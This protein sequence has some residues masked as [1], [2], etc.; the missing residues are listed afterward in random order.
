MFQT[1]LRWMGARWWAT[2]ALAS[3]VIVMFRMSAVDAPSSTLSHSPD[4]PGAHGDRVSAAPVNASFRKGAPASESRSA[5]LQFLALRNQLVDI[6]RALRLSQARVAL[7]SDSYE[8]MTRQYDEI[9]RLAALLMEEAEDEGPSR[10][11]TP[12]ERALVDRAVTLMR[13]R[14][15][16]KQAVKTQTAAIQASSPRG[17]YGVP[18]PAEAI[19]IRT[20]QASSDPKQ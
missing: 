8:S 11:R 14:S 13:E 6:E 17:A 3:T 7:Y 12:E 16:A 9:S 20:V 19:F 5:D 1:A 2:A 4:H 10:T 15:D 18:V